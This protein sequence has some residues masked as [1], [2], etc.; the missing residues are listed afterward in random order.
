MRVSH[1]VILAWSLALSPWLPGCDG[2]GGPADAGD[3]RDGQEADGDGVDGGD[4]ATGLAV[5]VV[6]PAFGPVEGGSLVTVAGR[7]F[8][9]G[10]RVVFGAAEGTG[11]QFVSA[12]QLRVTTPPAPGAPGRVAVEVENPGGERASL[13]DGF[14]YQEAH[15]PRVGWCALHWPAT[16]QTAPGVASEPIFGRVFAQ[17]CSEGAAQCTALSAQLGHGP[18]GLDPS[19]SPDAFQWQAALYNPGHTADDNDEYQA[20]LTI[21]M[22]GQV[23]Y[24]YRF[25]DDGGLSYTYCDL[26][27]S[28]NGLQTDQ[29]GLLSVAAVQWTIGW[30][31]LQHPPATAIAAG[32]ETEPI[33]GRVYVEG[34]S[35]GGLHCAA[36]TA[37]LGL[38]DPGQ[39]PSQSPGAF[40]WFSALHNSAH[41]EDD[42]DEYTARLTPAVEGLYAY[43]YRFS[44]DGGQS[45]TYC[46]LDGSQNGFERS[47][48]GAL[49]ARAARP[50]AWCNLQYPAEL[51]GQVGQP[52]GSV[53]GRVLVVG[54]SEGEARCDDVRAELG[55]GPDQVDPSADPG[56]FAWSEAAYNPGH[57]SDDNDEYQAEWTPDQAGLYR[58]L[59]RFSGDGGRT[60]AYCDLGG[61]QD[62]F[63]ASDLGR[64]SVP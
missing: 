10:A 52:T 29:L 1:C 20:S 17:G 7:G 64:L 25:S 48:M 39:N 4:S 30:C 61:S 3:G 59:Y 31:N 58:Y 14:E 15:R 21:G 54:C 2:G 43:A 41:A 46:D 47:Q 35:E 28:Q 44:A 34:C 18:V 23:A 36:V 22:I 49:T 53:F 55:V 27:G 63:D 42:N 60:W 56:A 16:A 24:A 13:P 38:G 11:V 8:L 19:Q 33:F 32:Q 51:T 12:T 62:G 37:E 57:T 50:I 9:D 40:Q 5:L 45:F 6:N 26:D